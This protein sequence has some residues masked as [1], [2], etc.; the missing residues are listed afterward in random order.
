MATIRSPGSNSA[1]PS[2]TY[3]RRSVPHF[4][5]LKTASRRSNTTCSQDPTPLSVGISFAMSRPEATHKVLSGRHQKW[6]REASPAVAAKSHSRRVRM[7]LRLV[8]V[9]AF[10]SMK[11][12]AG[13]PLSLILYDRMSYPLKLSSSAIQRTLS[14]MPNLFKIARSKRSESCSPVRPVSFRR[15]NRRPESVRPNGPTIATRFRLWIPAGR[16][17]EGTD[18]G[19]QI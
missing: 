4:N 11:I 2:I 17:S 10:T 8:E 9:V 7:K 6:N 3:T 13:S 14:S 16:R 18:F 12:F 1:K 5:V 15:S 19:R